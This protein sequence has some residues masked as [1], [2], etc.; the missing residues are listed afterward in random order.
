MFRS[1]M[2][3][4]INIRK[5]V[6]SLMLYFLA[7]PSLVTSVMASEANLQK[8]LARAQFMLKK[9][10]SENRAL[11]QQTASLQGEIEALKNDMAV[12]ANKAKKK[13]VKLKATLSKWKE[14]HANVKEKWFS[15]RSDLH[16]ANN[17]ITQLDEKLLTQTNNFDICYKNNGKLF[18]IN[19][20]LLSY[21]EGKSAV[22][23][24][25]Q[26][27]PILQLKKVE[28]ENLVQDY[29]YKIEDLNLSMMN[30]LIMPVY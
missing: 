6:L 7:V 23:S 28:V 30:H 16:A 19:K 12:A 24:L 26:K 14:S 4:K 29:R 22:D 2:M 9:M 17:D 8:A 25:L 13:E 18:D 20:E 3:E 27:E 5:W 1:L 21:Y 15:T 11:Q 10:D